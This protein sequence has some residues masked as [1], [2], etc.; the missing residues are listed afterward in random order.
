MELPEDRA[1]LRRV[2][3]ELYERYVKLLEDSHWGMYIAISLEGESVIG[4]TLIGVAEEASHRLGKGHIIYKIGPRSVR[5]LRSPCRRS[6]I[7]Q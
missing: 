3:D 2:Y 5:K 6:R 1:E 4:Q 7:V